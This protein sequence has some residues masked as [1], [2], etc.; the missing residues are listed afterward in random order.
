[1]SRVED[2]LSVISGSAVAAVD[3]ETYHDLYVEKTG[4][5]TAAGRPHS[6]LVS[7]VFGKLGD[8][9]S[10]IV[11]FFVGVVA[12]DVYL[13]NLLPDGLEGIDCVVKNTCGQSYTYGLTGERVSTRCR[14]IQL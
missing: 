8:S 4:N 6:L 12:F 2:R 10:D 1:L 9:N 14:D 11:G 13:A 3:H 7:P 5:Q